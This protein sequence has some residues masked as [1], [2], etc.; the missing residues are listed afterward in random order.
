MTKG[1]KFSA[2]LENMK[3]TI[4]KELKIDKIV[5]W[6]SKKLNK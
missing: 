6:L 2:A 5:E 1:Q 3:L 4:A